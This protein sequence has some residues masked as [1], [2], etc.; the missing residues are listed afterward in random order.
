MEGL[1]SKHETAFKARGKKERE[2]LKI[3][4]TA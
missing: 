4:R 2:P 1:R 3:Q